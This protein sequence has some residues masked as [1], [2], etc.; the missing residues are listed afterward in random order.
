MKA[1]NVYI[2][3][4]L[5]DW[6]LERRIAWH[7]KQLMPARTRAQKMFHWRCMAAGIH[8]RSPRQ[9][10]RMEAARGLGPPIKRPVK[11]TLRWTDCRGALKSTV[12]RPLF[13]KLDL[14]EL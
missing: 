9:V 3:Q 1:M 10:E 14:K 4:R 2:P 13:E 5:T 7:S 8:A 12:V 11:K 6:L